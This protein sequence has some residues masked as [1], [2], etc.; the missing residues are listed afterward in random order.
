M[1][2]IRKSPNL[3]SR[4]LSY[5]KL[6]VAIE[7]LEIDG[8]I[9]FDEFKIMPFHEIRKQYFSVPNPT[10]MDKAIIM[11]TDK[12]NGKGGPS[13]HKT[14]TEFYDENGN[15]KKTITKTQYF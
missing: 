5:E 2:I 12:R 13:E 9:S 14:I 1:A 15:V 4:M 7:Q 6:L 10:M 11:I 8:I 3:N